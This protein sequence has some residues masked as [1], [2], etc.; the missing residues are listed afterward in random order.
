MRLDDALFTAK[1]KAQQTYLINRLEDD[2]VNLGVRG[3]HNKLL[4]GKTTND[5][6]YHR[7][8]AS[9]NLLRC[10]VLNWMGHINCFKPRTSQGACLNA[11]R[12]NEL[13]SRY[14]H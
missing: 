3:F 9:G 11:G 8:G 14:R 5:L 6:L 4:L 13:I 2:L 10:L 12:C 7:V 1:D